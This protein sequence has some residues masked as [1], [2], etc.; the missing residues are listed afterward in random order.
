MKC[1]GCGN[2]VYRLHGVHG[3]WLCD[4]CKDKPRVVDEI[5]QDE[6][7]TELIESIKKMIEDSDIP[8]LNAVRYI[9]K[10]DKINIMVNEK[11]E[12]NIVGSFKK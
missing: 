10:S 4:D 8:R 11:N 2:D 6:R 9:L 5:W 1:E 3:C 7:R 12:I